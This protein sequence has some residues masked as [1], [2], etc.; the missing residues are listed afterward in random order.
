[1]NKF[2]ICIHGGGSGCQ[3]QGGSGCTFHKAGYVHPFPTSAELENIVKAIPED[4]DAAGDKTF[5]VPDME[6]D[7]EDD[8]NA[9]EMLDSASME[10]DLPKQLYY[11]D[12]QSRSGAVRLI[13]L[14]PILDPEI[15][16][17]IYETIWPGYPVDDDEAFNDRLA[18]LEIRGYMLDYLVSNELTDDDTRPRQTDITQNFR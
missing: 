8:A 14:L 15:I 7:I 11:F 1:M 16:A 17:E 6:P 10:K 12:L 3:R 18:R 4:P 9:E 13:E 2:E 5:D